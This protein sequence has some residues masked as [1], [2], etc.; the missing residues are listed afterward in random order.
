MRSIK[1]VGGLTPGRGLTDNAFAKWI[2]S[3]PQCSVI[4]DSLEKFSGI[5]PTFSEQH[6]E[7][8][9][10]RIDRDKYDMKKIVDWFSDH[11]PF[12]MDKKS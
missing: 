3:M 11:S 2:S 9:D 4:S 10:S 5:T 8:R 12:D 6:K 1:T 7:L